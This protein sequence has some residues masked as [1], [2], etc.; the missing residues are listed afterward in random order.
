M[1]DKANNA[2]QAQAATTSCQEV[3]HR[4]QTWYSG[5]R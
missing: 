4:Y 3:R 5:Y 1:M 2:A